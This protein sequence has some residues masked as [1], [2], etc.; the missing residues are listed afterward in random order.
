MKHNLMYLN[1]LRKI[2]VLALADKTFYKKQS[3]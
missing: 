2:I 1:K 3:F